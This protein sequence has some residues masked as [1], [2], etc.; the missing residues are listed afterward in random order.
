METSGYGQR[1][2]RTSQIAASAG[3]HPNTVRLYEQWGFLPPVPRLK[4]GYRVY[5]EKH[6]AHMR[7]ARTALKCDYVAGGI[8]LRAAELVKTAAGGELSKALDM[9][10]G[11]LAHIREEQAK[12]EEALALAQRWVNGQAV[13][14]E[15]EGCTTRG[16]AAKLLGTTIDIIRDWERN[17]L[18]DIP[19][20]KNN[21]RVYGAKE[22]GRLKIIMTLRAA[23][24]SMMSVLRMLTYADKNDIRDIRAVLDTP[25]PGEDIVSAA[26]RWISSLA[27]TESDAIEVIKQ[28]RE[29]TAAAE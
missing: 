18:A 29:I 3:V 11:Y 7:L 23:N 6:I 24:Y 9:A 17:G 26:D 12:A 21:Y 10:C 22:I 8:R 15:G 20:A 19:R 25:M 28:L 4:N 14:G 13:W 27:A 2:Y 16:G 5:S 1:T